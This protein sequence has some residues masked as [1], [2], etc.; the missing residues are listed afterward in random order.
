M[1]KSRLLLIS[2]S[3][4]QVLSPAQ[5]KLDFVMKSGFLLLKTFHNPAD[6]SIFCMHF[7]CSF[8]REYKPTFVNKLV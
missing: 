1:N 5:K 8:K 7:V 3:G 4:V 6:N 2:W